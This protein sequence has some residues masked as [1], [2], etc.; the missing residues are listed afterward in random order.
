MSVIYLHGIVLIFG[1][2][3]LNIPLLVTIGLITVRPWPPYIRSYIVDRVCTIYNT[4][5]LSQ[6]E[7]STP[8]PIIYAAHPHSVFPTQSFHYAA[9]DIPLA[10][11]PNMM[12]SLLA[13]LTHSV[14]AA[15]KSF[16][17][18]LLTRGTILIFPG[19]A[20]E[21]LLHQ[22][23]TPGTLDLYLHTG[24]FHIAKEYNALIVPSLCIDEVDRFRTYAHATTRWLWTYMRLAVC[25][26]TGMFGIPFIPSVSND[27]RTTIRQSRLGIDALCYTSIDDMITAYRTEVENMAACSDIRIKWHDIPQT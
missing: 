16:I 11:A 15:R 14:S 1:V 6:F 13:R 23:H 25:V 2:A 17:T 10:V 26:N 21:M 5:L 19:G 20:D 7:R 9:K 22:T 8:R 12:Y 27:Q 4:T 3:T 24:M 18:T